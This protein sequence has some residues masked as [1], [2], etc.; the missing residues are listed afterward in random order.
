MRTRPPGKRD[1]EKVIRTSITL[2]PL[3]F[4]ASKDLV[5]RGGYTGLSDCLQSLIRH[6]ANLEASARSPESTL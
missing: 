2:T 3:L 6:A 5:R 4:N 1:H